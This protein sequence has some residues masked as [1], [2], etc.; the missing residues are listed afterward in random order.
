LETRP[1][2][3]GPA[4]AIVGALGEGD[5]VVLAVFFEPHGPQISK[6]SPRKVNYSY[7]DLATT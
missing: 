2:A 7:G 3:G 4:R 1:S 6:L 5:G